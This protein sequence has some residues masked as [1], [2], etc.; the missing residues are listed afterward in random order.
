MRSV[1]TYIKKLRFLFA[2]IVSITVCQKAATAQS[3]TV[4][5]LERTVNL[6]AMN[7]ETRDVLNQISQQ[8]DVTFSY[9]SR[10]FTPAS[11]INMMVVDKPVRLVLNNLFQGAVNY[12]V[13]GRYIILTANH[14]FGT[15]PSSVGARRTIEG[16]ITEPISGKKLS[17]V[18]IYDKHSMASAITNEYGYFKLT[19][20][21]GEYSPDVKVSKA[22]YLDMA[23]HQTKDAF[24]FIA[25]NLSLDSLKQSLG[26]KKDGPKSDTL[27]WFPEWLI[28]RR[29]SVNTRNLSD[30]LFRN[31]QVSFLPYAGTNQLITGN[32]EINY[33]FNV[34]AGYNQGVRK[35]E[36]GG[37]LNIVRDS[38]RYVQVAGVGN[39]VGKGMRGVQVAGV[40]NKTQR[41]D[42]VQ[43]AG[44]LN[45]VPEE[46]R[47]IQV[48]GV[49]NISL[50]HHIGVQHAG[51][52]NLVNRLDGVQYAGIVN[53]AK[54]VS[55]VQLAGIYN[56]ARYIKG[57]QLASVVNYAD[58]VS[59]AQ[60]SFIVNSAK[61]V[62]GI[63]LGLV[64]ISDTCSGVPI[65]LFSYVK[66]GY[67]NLEISADEV[68]YANV[69]Y[70]SGVAAF[71]SIVFAGVKPKTSADPLLT[72]GFGM[73]TTH[74][75]TRKLFFDADITA[76]QMLT[77]DSYLENSHLY[78]VY[79]G[80]EH[81]FSNNTSLAAGGT[82]NF[83][84]FDSTDAASV[85]HLSTL[86]P[87]TI[88]DKPNGKGYIHQTW[89]GWKVAFRFY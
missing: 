57:A 22:G 75:L 16:Y 64:N 83:M 40:F 48:S 19:I 80:I 44:V 23:L 86:A 50:M 89:L 12:K 58:T 42:G 70:R 61:Y 27:R 37:V 73:G 34:L 53:V 13:K 25:V 33:S 76:Q 9:S 11:N 39:F 72:Y 55:G 38:V 18:T 15:S 47:F 29:L 26:M 43:V 28:P 81:R 17:G 14:D 51:V 74:H 32:V 77:A 65:G 45:I 60:M 30:T 78:K 1:I 67:H 54:I 62:K 24:S 79:M 68:F 8:A 71:H 41:M 52:F 87:Y 36:L 66:K 84:V 5:P 69:A 4:P 10:A 7:A 82:F 20:P 46:S 63:Q 59:G 2:L 21:E 88:L 49:G 31:A 85:K 35:A 56:Q 6:N 3:S